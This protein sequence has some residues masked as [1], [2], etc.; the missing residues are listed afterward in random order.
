MIKKFAL[1]LFAVVLLSPAY[2]YASPGVISVDVEGKSVNLNYD[3][4]GLEVLS[5]T[6]DLDF[7]SL[8]FEV[9]VTG[10][11]GILEITFDRNFFDS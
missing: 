2:V 5:V 11:P 4:E 6:P 8:I 3:A 10:S 9:D 7:T 1:A